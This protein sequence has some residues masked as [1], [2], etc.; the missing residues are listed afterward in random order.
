MLLQ[1]ILILNTSFKNDTY[2][3]VKKPKRE[4]TETKSDSTVTTT[5]VEKVEFIDD[6]NQSGSQRPGASNNRRFKDLFE[7]QIDLNQPNVT[8]IMQRPVDMGETKRYKRKNFEEL[9]KRRTYTCKYD[10]CLKSYTKSSH[11]KAHSRIHT[12]EKPYHCKWPLCKWKFARSVTILFKFSHCY[13]FKNTISISVLAI[14]TDFETSIR[15][16][17]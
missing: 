6:E 11:L 12:G 3:K 9:E 4:A 7:P 8:T 5:T 16:L 1:S 10:G 2:K 17:L 14:Q 15:L 13:S